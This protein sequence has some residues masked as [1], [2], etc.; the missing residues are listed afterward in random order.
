MEPEKHLWFGFVSVDSLRA[1][2]DPTMAVHAVL[3]MGLI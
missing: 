1:Q 2:P 3:S